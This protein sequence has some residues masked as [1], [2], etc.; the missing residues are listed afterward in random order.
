MKYS[1]LLFWLI[2]F[3]IFT[4]I[5]Q[6]QLEYLFVNKSRR[7]LKCNWANSFGFL[8]YRMK[9]NKVFEHLIKNPRSRD[10]LFLETRN[11]GFLEWVCISQSED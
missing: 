6:L 7:K 5:N 10:I 2:F 1:V 3:V 9:K 4:F 8:P 11:Q